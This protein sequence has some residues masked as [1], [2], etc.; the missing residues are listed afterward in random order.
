MNG[1]TKASLPSN[2]KVLSH[3]SIASK[4]DQLR[5]Q[6]LSGTPVRSLINELSTIIAIEATREIPPS[7]KIAL[8]VVLR[9]GLPMCDPF[10]DHLPPSTDVAVYHLGLY[11]ERT[12]LEP[13]EYYNKLPAQAPVV[14]HAYVVDPLIATG[15]TAGATVDILRNWGVEHITFLSILASPQG[16][17]AV[18]NV[19][20]EGVDLVV[21]HVDETVDE[22]GY[23]Q[24]GIGD[25]GDR[26]YGTALAKTG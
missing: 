7:E 21:G 19:W 10:L 26:L 8:I 17:A 3:P 12:T 5:D 2:V 18:A 24:P 20:P 15:G 14:K 1:T 22:K 4:L 23:I 25:I 6:S 9:A 13:V 11:R 16:L